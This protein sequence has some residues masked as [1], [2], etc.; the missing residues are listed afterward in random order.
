MYALEDTVFAVATPFGAGRT[1]V[2]IT[3]PRALDIGHQ[4]LTEPILVKQN[5]LS[6]AILQIAPS[7]RWPTVA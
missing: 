3:G 1:I 5:R 4:L 2:R 7:P 6:A